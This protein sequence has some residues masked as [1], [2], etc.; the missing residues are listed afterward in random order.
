MNIPD[1][2]KFLETY[3]R[4]PLCNLSQFEREAA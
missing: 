3:L 1:A 4:S 2:V